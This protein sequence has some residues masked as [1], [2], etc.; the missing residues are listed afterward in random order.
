VV[1]A[2]GSRGGFHVGAGTRRLAGGT[3]G[4]PQTARGVRAVPPEP[5]IPFATSR[6]LTKACGGLS[7]VRLP[8]TRAR[9][10]TTPP[11]TLAFCGDRINKMAKQKR[12]V[13]EVTEKKNKKL[14]KA[15]AKEN[16]LAPEAMPG[17]KHAHPE[18]GARGVVAAS[19]CFFTG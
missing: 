7:H 5:V 9:G 8:Q 6:P 2:R 10:G 12:K 18:V 16:L 3:G 15:S 17:T 1:G 4:V 11:G 14:K 13:T 19:A